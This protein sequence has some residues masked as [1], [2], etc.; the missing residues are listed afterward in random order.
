MANNSITN[1]AK[2]RIR[3]LVEA[4]IAN[5]TSGATIGGTAFH[6][7]FSALGNP[8]LV[9]AAYTGA[10]PVE[11]AIIDCQ[12]FAQLVGSGIAGASTTAASAMNAVNVTSL[13]G[14]TAFTVASTTGF[15]ASPG[16]VFSCVTSTG[17]AWFGY[18]AVSGAT[19][20]NCILLSGSGTI[21]TGAV[22]TQAATSTTGLTEC[23]ATGYKRQLLT[24]LTSATSNSTDDFLF[25]SADVTWGGA[26]AITG[27]STISK[28]AIGFMPCVGSSLIT[29]TG[30]TGQEPGTGKATDGS[31]IPISVHDFAMPTDGTDITVT[32]SNIGRAA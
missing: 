8:G 29:N 18:T 15:A 12:S 21:S 17:L 22:V 1:T 5:Q 19:L 32:V 6:V 3:T 23:T 30:N 9:V 2:G 26:S 4:A 25:D 20:T 24:S 27:A 16:G 13:N 14:T 31:I 28:I 10:A 7:P 11:A